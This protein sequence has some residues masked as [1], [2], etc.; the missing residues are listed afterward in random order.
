MELK[1][2][3]K[4][5]EK[6][7]IFILTTVIIGGL[8]AFIISSNTQSGYSLSQTF[9]ISSN[10]IKK[11]EDLSANEDYF[12]QEKARNF[13]DSAIAILESEDFKSKVA[14]DGQSFSVRK[15]APQV[16][17]ITSSASDPQGASLLMAKIPNQFNLKISSLDE[18]SPLA[19]KEISP[20]KDPSF[21][22]ADKKIYTIA[23]LVLAL[24][25]ALFTVSLKTYFKL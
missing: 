17:K 5:F 24:A 16:I 14:E 18:N 3:L 20:A 10:I 8:L 1:T 22:K 13:T 11:S 21:I 7:K 6:F 12:A 23:G 25:L 15:L 4:D 2:Y 19:L 9:F